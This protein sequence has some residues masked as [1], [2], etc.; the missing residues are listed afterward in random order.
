MDQHQNP[1]D[2]QSDPAQSITPFD[3]SVESLFDFSNPNLSDTDLANA[4]SASSAPSDSAK[5][6]SPIRDLSYRG[7][8]GPLRM[9]AVRWW[10]IATSTVRAATRKPVFWVGVGMCMLTYIFQALMLYFEM[11]VN[12]AIPKDALL[13]MSTEIKFALRFFSAQCGQMNAFGQLIIALLAGAGAIAADNRANALLVYLSKPLSKNDYVFG[14][15]MGVFLTLF[16][17][18]IIP[19][20]ILY[21][22]CFLSY[23]SEEFFKPDP[24]LFGRMLLSATIAPAIHASGILG[25]SA[26]SK[27]PS[28][29]GAIYTGLYMIGGFIAGLLGGVIEFRQKAPEQG[30]LIKHLS[31]SG[32]IDGLT[33]NI[34]RVDIPHQV[35][36][37]RHMPKD[38]P[39]FMSD[40]PPALWPLLAL[41]AIIILGGFLIARVRI[42]AVE[43]VRG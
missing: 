19:G 26:W 40:P 9:R 20:L 16:L 13:G 4:S 14:K 21:F 6:G 22:Y 18:T 23:T 11:R 24:W 27:S 30:I 25:L 43:V 3:L 1:T 31:I 36:R 42:Q 12:Q 33:Q 8:D 5:E 15:W 32:V 34:Y 10:I 17:I 35:F 29:T 37:P 7:Y 38:M 2:N 41:A 39:Q 28:I